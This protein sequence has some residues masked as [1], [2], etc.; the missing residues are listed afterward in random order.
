MNDNSRNALFEKYGHR[1][2]INTSVPFFQQTLTLVSKICNSETAC[3]SFIG[4][5]CHYVISQY[6]AKFDKV[7]NK[8]PVSQAHSLEKELRIINNPCNDDID[9]SLTFISDKVNI[10]FYAEMPLIDMDGHVIGCLYITDKQPKELTKVQHESLQLSSQQAV[11]FLEMRKA[12]SDDLISNKDQSS[13]LPLKVEEL[14]SDVSALRLQLKDQET[15]LVKVRAQIKHK[16]EVLKQVLDTFPGLV[17][18]IN[19]EY[20]YE[21]VNS[22]YFELTGMA[23]EL[24]A[25]KPIVEVVGTEKYVKL[26]PLYERVFKGE[27][28]SNEGF[29]DFKGQ[30]RYLKVSYYPSYTKGEIDGAYVLTEDFTEIK[31][32][33]FQLENSNKSLENFAHVVSHD[34]QSPLRTINSFANLLKRDL[35]RRNIEYNNDYLNFIIDGAL[36]LNQLTTDLLDFAKVKQTEVVH[37]VISLN[38]LLNIVQL[39]LSALM[40]E[41]NAKVIYTSTDLKISGLMTDFILLFQNLISNAIKYSKP[42][43]PPIVQIEFSVK[44][45]SIEFSII[46]NGIGIPSDRRNDIFLPFKRVHKVKVDGTGVG[47][48]TCANIVQKY[49]SKIYL[50]SKVNVGSSFSFSLPRYIKENDD[51]E[52]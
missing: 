27:H 31:T 45:D 52:T 39:N 4:D 33:Q 42:D 44:R 26:L 41:K 24:L 38:K 2:V 32:Y 11:S 46:D 28:I 9:K 25:G 23:P 16:N 30:K 29:F 13:K 8:G 22:R 14:I 18:K 50:D 20:K 15:E 6:G 3:I 37:Q 36:N 21:F 17:S 40:T 34:I 43:I 10:G 5:E 1:G 49:N 7:A 12:L 47:L 48:A 51:L 35:D 19:R